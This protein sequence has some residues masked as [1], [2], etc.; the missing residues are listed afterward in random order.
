MSHKSSAAAGSVTGEEM[1]VASIE[2]HVVKG[3]TNVDGELEVL[4]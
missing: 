4:G 1:L 2:Q 3:G